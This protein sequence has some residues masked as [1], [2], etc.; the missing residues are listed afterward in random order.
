MYTV[1][2]FQPGE[3]IKSVK[4]DCG[5]AGIKAKGIMWVVMLNDEPV[6]TPNRVT[7]KSELESYRRKYTAEQVA[8][9]FNQNGNTRNYFGNIE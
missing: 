7:G 4:I 1:R 6:F 9:Y 8:D 2:K 5:T 3:A